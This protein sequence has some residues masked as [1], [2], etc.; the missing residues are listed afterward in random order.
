MTNN[1]ND[2]VNI[3]AID[4]SGSTSGCIHY[5]QNVKKIIDRI[6]NDS[7]IIIEWNG[8]ANTT[9]IEDMRLRIDQRKGDGWTNP[10]SII[11]L[12]ANSSMKKINHFVLITDGEVETSEIDDCDKEIKNSMITFKRFEG[13]IIGYKQHANMSVTCPFTR[14]C[15]HNVIQIQPGMEEET[16]LEVSDEDFA[17]IEKIKTIDDV[18]EF[19]ILYPKMER[20]FA[21]R[22][23]GT[24]GDQE[25]RKEVV[26]MQHR[27]TMN[28]GKR[29]TKTSDSAKLMKYIE[30]GDI[31]NAISFAGKFLQIQNTE[32]EKSINAL[33]RMCDGGLRQVFDPSQIKSFRANIADNTEAVDTLDIDDVPTDVQTTFECPV[34][35]ENETDPV[36]LIA[37]PELPILKI[38]DNKNATDNIINCP[39]D[40]FFNKDA[41]EVM[42]NCIDHPLSLK[43]M[44][45]AENCHNPILLSPLT[46][47]KL[48]GGIPLGASEEHVKAANWTISQLTSGGKKLGNPDMWFS[49]IW[50]M[51]EQNMFPYL[52]DIIPFVR[53]QMI[54]RLKN[55]NTSASLS[56]LS[57]FCQIQIP[58]AGAC[59]FCLTSPYFI[60]NETKK[61]NMLRFHLSHA[62]ILKKMTDLVGFK[63]PDGFDRFLT[64]TIAFS[65]MIKFKRNNQILFQNLIHCLYQNS[66]C[67][68]IDEQ[69]H[70]VPIDGPATKESRQKVYQALPKSCRNLTP[71]EIVWLSKYIDINKSATDNE[72]PIN[73]DPQ[74]LPKFDVNWSEIDEKYLLF[75]K[76]EIDPITMRPFKII[77]E[78]NWKDIYK[79][80]FGSTARMLVGCDIA[81]CKFVEN[82]SRYPTVEEYIVSYAN[83]LFAMQNPITTLPG[84]IIE[85]VQ[86]RILAFEQSIKEAEITT[87]DEVVMRFEGSKPIHLKKNFHFYFTNQ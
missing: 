42:K 41:L 78:I 86:F 67:I 85:I 33:I 84:R 35:Y 43:T 81:F 62:H 1:S 16:I 39:L 31:E 29:E 17:T 69:K 74:T 37:K 58:L 3:I 82:H 61:Q 11:K 57:T 56:C 26:K 48:I 20:V 72:F 40:I 70:F 75:E 51:I 27:I 68:E 66:L 87:P 8:K 76:V 47:K 36:I 73:E 77:N 24:V 25:L 12:L 59:W 65:S 46:R 22:L 23:L 4:I 5:Y 13:Y 34:S 49:V 30:T 80:K 14:S 15:S 63:Y 53:E 64:R 9:T 7:Y 21:A 28:I 54:F 55:H 71:E 18:D 44:R 45:E 10:C 19:M 60:T 38:I 50:M 79:N 2:N 83:R 52:N 32:Y 6:F